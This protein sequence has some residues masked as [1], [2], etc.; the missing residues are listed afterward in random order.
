MV[1]YIKNPFDN[2]FTTVNP[3]Y[4]TLMDFGTNSESYLKALAKNKAF[5]K[6]FTDLIIKL[7]NDLIKEFG[8]FKDL[9]TEQITQFNNRLDNIKEEMKDF[10]QEWAEDGTIAHLINEVL[11]EQLNQKIED[12]KDDLSA[13]DDKVD[14]VIT[15]LPTKVLYPSGGD[16]TQQITDAW[17]T[18]PSVT[19]SPGE[20]TATLELTGNDK[21]LNG[22]GA[23]IRSQSSGY[24]IDVTGN[25]NTIHG[26]TLI[27]N[28]SR[29]G[30]RIEGEYNR[31]QQITAQA[32]TK[33]TTGSALSYV[34]LILIR[35]SYNVLTQSTALNGGS[36][37]TV[38]AGDYNIVSHCTS[39]HNTM[40]MRNAPSGRYTKIT[41]NQF[42]H[43]NVTTVS[44]A[45]GILVHR[46]STGVVVSRNHVSDNG[47]HGI[48][49]QGDNTIVSDNVV[50][51]NY[52]DGIKAGAHQTQLYQH[53]GH[54]VSHHNL[55]SNN[56]S[57]NNDGCGIYYQTPFDHITIT[58]NQTY[59][60][61]DEGI[62]VVSMGQSSSYKLGSLVIDHNDTES[63]F[64]TGHEYTEIRHNQVAGRLFTTATSTDATLRM[65]N[66]IIS[67]NT[68]Q[69]M[70]ISR[71]RNSRISNNTVT[72]QVTIQDQ[73]HAVLT[74]NDFTLSSSLNCTNL[75]E[76][77]NNRI[78]FSNG[79]QLTNAGQIRRF[80]N[81][82]LESLSL[83]SE[84]FV[85]APD[86]NTGG[87]V[88][89]IGNHFVIN[90]AGAFLEVFGANALVSGN[91]FEGGSSSTTTIRMR[92]DNAVVTG[93]TSTN[94][95]RVNFHSNGIGKHNV[96]AFVN[97]P[98]SQHLIS[99][100]WT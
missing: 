79:G 59:G 75:R 89:V 27:N 33:Y 20:Y 87:R 11:F 76:F 100:N 1:D 31:V 82:Y 2:Y 53:S 29:E 64:I 66:P 41:D 88:H 43:N 16:D 8:E 13:L 36:G 85:Y 52:N 24:V 69:V 49:F 57:Y 35:G 91:L 55:I 7:N 65:L 96:L 51:D 45:D 44:G 17:N 21:H 67:G 30:L 38:Q 99:D 92:G 98:G 86:W 73:A 80:I 34:P 28:T 10:F 93:N 22:Q 58:D 72:D 95:A 54:Y 47:E 97:T 46:N 84:Q 62:K 81:N 50:H 74:G 40:G 94:S 23:V 25:R 32:D 90:S 71:A 5:M 4:N 77:I 56:V 42:N 39:N 3:T 61:S 19:L 70:S 68:C 63:L 78:R 6:Q 48:Y 37:I 9:T 26:L 14:E 15:Q 60:N 12:L 18:Y 83:G